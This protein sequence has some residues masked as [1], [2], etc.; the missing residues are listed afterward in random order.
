[1]DEENSFVGMKRLLMKSVIEAG[2]DYDDDGNAESRI[3]QDDHTVST[4]I[5][6]PILDYYDLRRIKYEEIY[7][8]W[9]FHDDSDYLS[10]KEENQVGEKP[11]EVIDLTAGDEYEQPRQPP[12]INPPETQR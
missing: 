12:Q 1:M 9:R 2:I 10:P 4:K 5:M 3:I 6:K 7:G 8:D 11:E